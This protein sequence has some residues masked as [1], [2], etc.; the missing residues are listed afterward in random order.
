MFKSN[1]MKIVY[2]KINELKP[3]EYNPRKIT[4]TGKK[5][6]QESLDTLGTLKPA[7]INTYPGREDIIISGHQ[8]INIAKERGD[9][10]YPCHEVSF[11]P[12]KEK[13]ANIRLNVHNGTWDVDLLGAEFDAEE[14]ESWGASELGDLLAGSGPSEGEG[15]IKFSEELDEES[16]FVVLKFDKD[17]DFTN[18][19]TILNLPST[20]SKRQNGKPWSK[21]IGRV[22]NGPQ[23]IEKFKAS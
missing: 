21:G 3:A 7:V 5:N 11:D 12:E 17:I 23:A 10:E 13:E 1:K 22:V 19:E 18:I 16:N 15:D 6:L 2:R 14:L 20:F 4:D 9:S 8:S